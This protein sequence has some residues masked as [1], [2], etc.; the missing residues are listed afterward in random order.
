MPGFDPI[1]LRPEEQIS[2]FSPGDLSDLFELERLPIYPGKE[3]E[4]AAQQAEQAMAELETASAM[5]E[6]IDRSEASALSTENTID[7]DAMLA[8]QMAASMARFQEE[9]DDL[10][11]YQPPADLFDTQVSS[12]DL[13][14][15][16]EPDFA[17]MN[18]PLSATFTEPEP[19]VP[20]T[21]SVQPEPF[22]PP[23]L[24][25]EAQIVA[26]AFPSFAEPLPTPLVSTV[27]PASSTPEPTRSEPEVTMSQVSVVQAP[28]PQ[29]TTGK[30]LPAE[31]DPSVVALMQSELN[32]SEKRKQKKAEDRIKQID[33][34]PIVA[35]QMQGEERFVDVTAEIHDP[36][37]IVQRDGHHEDG[38][39]ARLR[40]NFERK[41]VP[42]G[43]AHQS[44][45][46]NSDSLFTRKRIMVLGVPLL[47]F[48]V[49]GV[50]AYVWFGVLHKP[51]P[52]FA[53]NSADSTKVH[54][55]KEEHANAH[56]TE[57]K[58]AYDSS[59][60]PMHYDSIAQP[61]TEALADNIGSHGGNAD[62]SDKHA[63]EVTGGH[64]S[65]VKDK[66]SHSNGHAEQSQKIHREKEVLRASEEREQ[67][68]HYSKASTEKLKK[69]R[70]KSDRVSKADKAKTDKR[71]VASKKGAEK[72]TSIT[73]T[74]V[75][76]EASA[77][78]QQSSMA[79]PSS[80]GLFSVQ[81]YASPSMEDAEQWLNKLRQ[82]KINGGFVSTQEVR[83]KKW[84]RV[85]FGSYSTMQEAEQMA[86]QSGFG[87]AW[88]VRLR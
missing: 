46:K 49:L 8:A 57:G 30:Q 48:I 1:A 10:T 59:H 17:Q 19:F 29:D 82:K 41:K 54:A 3:A 50:S 76:A 32:R 22:V 13:E 42:V 58:V 64:G 34:E 60:V 56:S 35:K 16:P 65:S 84:Y 67:I 53:K 73:K 21:L 26:E 80:S 36:P 44:S 85:R 4:L 12:D 15:L 87:T 18:Q 75:L 23:I 43:S 27:P 11:N 14:P 68:S 77:S 72:H 9:D 88:V 40:K 33:D 52:F 6:S 24:T 71:I 86:S 38:I 39:F 78:K 62:V 51:L 55:K 45:S 66:E 20:P 28:I 31:L 2:G 69:V 74:K 25:E 83:G 37:F 47:L 7:A 79:K 63:D 5:S 81:V 70:T 61:H